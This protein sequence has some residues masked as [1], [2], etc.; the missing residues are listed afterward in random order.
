MLRRL[1][2]CH[3]QP[4]LTVLIWLGMTNSQPSVKKWLH[5]GYTAEWNEVYR[6]G[7]LLRSGL[8]KIVLNGKTEFTLLDRIWTENGKMA[9]WSPKKSSNSF[10]FIGFT[11]MVLQFLWETN[12]YNYC[13][14][15][16]VLFFHKNCDSDHSAVR[17][18]IPLPT[19]SE[20]PLKVI[21]A[22]ESIPIPIDSNF[23]LFG[24]HV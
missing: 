19:T 24:E 17:G 7:P 8:N 21:S 11:V 10:T 16:G 23:N 1:R 9:N 20:W 4:Y 12:A 3:T 14:E 2:V 18:M 5:H 13:D 22:T 6:T 15:N